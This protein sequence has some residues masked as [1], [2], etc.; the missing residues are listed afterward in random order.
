MLF[1]ILYTGVIQILA[2]SGAWN[3]QEIIFDIQIFF[4][5][6]YTIIIYHF[7]FLKGID[8]EIKRWQSLKTMLQKK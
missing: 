5:Q 3:H 6:S 7:I 4:F 1:F 8:L 2:I